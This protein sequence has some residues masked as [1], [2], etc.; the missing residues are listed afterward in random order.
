[1][2]K[3]KSLKFISPE[4]NISE[5]L[6]IIGS[7]KSILK[8]ENGEEIDSYHDVIR[9][10]KSP[11]KNYEKFIGSKTTIRVINNPVFECYPSWDND[12]EKDKN[13]VRYLSNMKILVVSPHKISDE[14]K[15]DVFIPSNQYF[16]LENKIYMYMS[17]FY[18]F[19]KIDILKD[20]FKIIIKK[21]NFSIGF[22]TILMC[23]ISGIKPTLFGF[24]MSEDM[25]T[26]SHYWETPGKPGK[27]HDLNIEHEI[28]KKFIHNKFVV[29]KD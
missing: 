11:V 5:N 25:S 27:W 10:N 2:K 21:K 19:F 7:S 18:F 17:I 12:D 4:I 9:F 6:A 20:L 13:F 15:N 1:M 14:K 24:D 8:K 23:V 16:F 3:Q 29:L 22:T 26:R 28:I